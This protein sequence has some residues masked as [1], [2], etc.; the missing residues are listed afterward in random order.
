MHA[1]RHRRLALPKGAS[2]LTCALALPLGL[3]ACSS[4]AAPTTTTSATVPVA[5]TRC[6]LIPP[7]KIR[8]DLGTTVA[9]PSA[10]VHG[11]TTV[12]TYKSA[13]LA[14]SVIIRY[15]SDSTT[16]SFAADR[17]LFRSKGDKVGK[18]EGLGD[19]AYY[20]VATSGGK[21]VHTVVA[22]HGN[23][24][25]LVTG[26]TGTLTQFEILTI[27][28]LASVSPATSSTSSTT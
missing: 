1:D 7:A 20:V 16:Q 10:T 14:D 22:R 13:D 15:D 28:A 25:V 5:D 18:I 27:Q 11:A 4:S 23:E 24:N 26:T 8:T 3:A 12:C 21:T 6:E 9:A 17:A 2:V 19:E